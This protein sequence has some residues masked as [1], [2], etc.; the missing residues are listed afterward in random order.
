M[1]DEAAFTVSSGNLYADLGFPEPDIALAK[2][3]LARQLIAIINERG[4]TQAAAGEVLGINQPKVSA[5]M[6]GR[7]KDFSLERLAQLLTK[8]NQ[9]I[10]ISV[11]PSDREGRFIATIPAPDERA[12]AAASPTKKR[13]AQFS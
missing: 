5:I 2:A 3:T 9:D 7:L 4:L 8:F 11:R 13:A 6:R 1:S 10:E 12:L